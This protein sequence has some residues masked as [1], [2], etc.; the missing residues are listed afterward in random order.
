MELNYRV[1]TFS[2]EE[3][4]GKAENLTLGSDLDSNS[5]WHSKRF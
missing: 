1:F 5:G 3:I 4:D 2:S